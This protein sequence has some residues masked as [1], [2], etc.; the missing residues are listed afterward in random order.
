MAPTQPGT[1]GC[2]SQRCDWPESGSRRSKRPASAGQLR[3][4]VSAADLIGNQIAAP[5]DLLAEGIPCLCCERDRW[6]PR[7][8]SDAHASERMKDL[9]AHQISPSSDLRLFGHMNIIDG[10]PCLC[11]EDRWHAR[12]P[13]HRG[14]GGN[15]NAR[16][17]FTGKTKPHSTTTGRSF[18][19]SPS[20]QMRAHRAQQR[21]NARQ[22]PPARPAS[23]W[24][25]PGEYCGSQFR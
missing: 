12:P 22:P 2:G 19:V 11:C 18:A 9:L 21:R 4:C 14:T 17:G 25:V 13:N 1:F 5:S 7:C 10:L 20:L 8:P 15:T 16:L 24:A 3:Q 23:A 6:G